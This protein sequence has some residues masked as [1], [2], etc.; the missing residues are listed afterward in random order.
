MAGWWS[1]RYAVRLSGI[2]GP[3]GKEFAEADLWPTMAVRR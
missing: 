3:Q 2:V 1:R